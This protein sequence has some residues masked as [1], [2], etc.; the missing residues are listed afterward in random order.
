[1]AYADENVA[2]LADELPA[3]CIADFGSSAPPPLPRNALKA[4]RLLR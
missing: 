3:R 1:M 4:L 2:W